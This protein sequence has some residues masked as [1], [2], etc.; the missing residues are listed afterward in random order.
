MR[1]RDERG[2]VVGG[3]KEEDRLIQIERDD[4]ME[5]FYLHMDGK[6]V[7][8]G[9]RQLLPGIQTD[10]LPAY[11]SEHRIRPVG[12]ASELSRRAPR[13]SF[14]LAYRQISYQLYLM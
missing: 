13:Y 6:G 4:G 8:A 7:S 10:Q 5:G 3:A 11:V 14:K 9:K 2:G 1:V 12:G